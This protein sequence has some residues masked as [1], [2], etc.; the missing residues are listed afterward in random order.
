MESQCLAQA[1]NVKIHILPS[2][3]KMWI[4]YDHIHFFKP[5]CFVSIYFFNF[6]FG[7]WYR[8]QLTTSWVIFLRPAVLISGQFSFFPTIVLLI[9]CV[10]SLLWKS[11]SFI[12]FFYIFFRML[13]S[14]L[15]VRESCLLTSPWSKR[16]GN[17][18]CWAFNW[19]KGLISLLCPR[20]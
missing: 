3:R 12:Q 10:W 19:N 20:M 5:R 11:F 4:G 1:A 14:C 6:V 17:F 15:W 9:H 7:V 16:V 8:L 2:L 18:S 13:M